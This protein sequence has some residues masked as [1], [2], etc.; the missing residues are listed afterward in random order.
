[1][2]NCLFMQA[3]SLIWGHVYA[4]KRHVKILLPYYYPS[5]CQRNIISYGI[6]ALFLTMPLRLHWVSS[7]IHTPAPLLMSLLMSCPASLSN[8]FPFSLT[9]QARSFPS[10]TF[11][12]TSTPQILITEDLANWPLLAPREQLFC[13]P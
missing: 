12:S 6:T 10:T 5:S 4:P 7:I 9:E 13:L 3:L 8:Y 11:A 1:M 2:S